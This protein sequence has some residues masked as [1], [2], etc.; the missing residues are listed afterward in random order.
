VNSNAPLRLAVIG[1]GRMARRRLEALVATG[2]VV[3]SGVAARRLDSA[4]AFAADFGGVPAF[5]DY[6]TLAATRPNAV[7]VEVPHHVQDAAARW[8]VDQ[9]WHLLLGGPL[10]VTTKAGRTLARAA[11]RRGVIVEAGF[12][13]RYKPVWE[14]AKTL[15]TSGRLGRVLTV[16]AVALWRCDP[17]SW[18]YDEAQSGG[19]PLTH[20]TYCF[21]NPLRWIFGEPLSVAAAANKLVQQSPSHVREETCCAL[22]RFP[23]DVLATLTAGYVRS[24][25]EGAWRVTIFGDRAT[26]EI[27]PAEAGPGSLRLLSDHEP[28]EFTFP[29][30]AD[31]FR[32]QA[33]AF[34][35]AIRGGPLCR[36]RPQDCLGD[37]LTIEAIS[38]A[39]LGRDWRRVP[40]KHL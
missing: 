19:M 38:Q 16:N 36:N 31:G 13:A 28:V 37:L 26:L 4:R 9:G 11:D 20:M 8:V 27:M 25:E 40:T 15:V 34:V 12:E 32:R 14:T 22:L 39:A 7:L 2:G 1:A 24:A 33:D 3:L 6:R 10:A 5:D 30:D 21:I 35:E 29:S 17:S 18:Y 23:C